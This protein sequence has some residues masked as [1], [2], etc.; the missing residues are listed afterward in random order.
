MFPFAGLAIPR[1]RRRVRRREVDLHGDL[2]V[3]A[4]AACC[5]L[6]GLLLERRIDMV[7]PDS[8]K[9]CQ[10]YIADLA[11]LF[12]SVQNVME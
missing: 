4:V 10:I 1:R 7:P 9:I 8:K 6:L 5:C 3:L 2:I 12:V 11:G